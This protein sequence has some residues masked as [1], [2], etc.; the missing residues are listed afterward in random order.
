MV[1]AAPILAALALHFLDFLG[2]CYLFWNICW[3]YTEIIPSNL[4]RKCVHAR[5]GCLLAELNSNLPFA[6]QAPGPESVRRD[7]HL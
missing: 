7:H 4:E 6:H 5:S 1:L 2:F 3:F